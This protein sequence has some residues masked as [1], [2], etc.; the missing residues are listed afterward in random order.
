MNEKKFYEEVCSLIPVNREGENGSEFRIVLSK[1]LS[2]YIK[3]IK[4]FGEDGKLSDDDIKD[5][6]KTCD[7]LKDIVKSEYKGLH[8]SA[9]TKLF[10]LILGKDQKTALGNSIIVRILQANQ[11]PLFRMR[12]MDN[13]RGVKHT[14]MF[15]IPLTKKG[16]VNTNRYSAPGFPCLYLGTSIYAC[17][18]ELGRPS[19][20]QSMVSRLKNTKD[21]TLLDLRIPSLDSFKKNMKEYVRAFPLIIACSVIVK[22]S[23]ALYKPEYIIP[24]LL[25][26]VI[27]K[28][29]VDNKHKHVDGV[30]Y[31]SVFKN[32]DLGFPLEK[33]ENIAIPVQNPLS[34]TKFCPKLCELF[35]I[36]RPTC[37]EIEQARSAG[38]DTISFENDQEVLHLNKG[39]TDSYENSS[40]AYLEKRLRDE[41]LFPLQSI[42]D[43][44]NT[45]TA[46]CT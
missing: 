10:N 38:Y 17:W 43:K 3:L 31:T 1:T 13:R 15:H 32:N 23:A 29:N 8:S 11:H 30:Y 19:M 42:S 22:D 2:K 9:F 33:N 18:E 14:E 6:V 39:C 41:N 35:T 36:T 45:D 21:L 5:S 44:P 26:E 16:I 27:I 28:N 7:K 46:H 20:S 25:M 24:Q 40:F 34:N 12:K 4:E 37:D